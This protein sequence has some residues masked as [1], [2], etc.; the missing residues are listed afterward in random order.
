M[1]EGSDTA[2]YTPKLSD[3]NRYVNSVMKASGKV[4]RPRPGPSD[5]IVPFSSSMLTTAVTERNTKMSNS[6]ALAWYS[7][8]QNPPT[9]RRVPA[10]RAARYAG[11]SRAV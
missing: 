1:V 5:S 11:R 6:V 9:A 7:V 4:S 3:V 8:R 2:Q 10:M